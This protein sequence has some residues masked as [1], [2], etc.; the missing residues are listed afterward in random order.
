MKTGRERE[1]ASEGEEEG[2]KRKCN[3]IVGDVMGYLD[4]LLDCHTEANNMYCTAYCYMISNLCVCHVLSLLQHCFISL[5]QSS[6]LFRKLFPSTRAPM[7]ES[8]HSTPA[9]SWQFCNR[10]FLCFAPGPNRRHM[11]HEQTIQ[12]EK[13]RRE[14]GEVTAKIIERGGFCLRG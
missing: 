11:R 10:H 5:V 6:L 4:S 3:S 9:P 7:L 13:P 1:R 14:I 8:H 12:L 2:A